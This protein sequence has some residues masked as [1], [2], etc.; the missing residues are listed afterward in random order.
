MDWTLLAPEVNLAACGYGRIDAEVAATRKAV[1]KTPLMTGAI[2][3]P[4]RMSERRY[5]DECS[6]ARLLRRACDANGGILIYHYP[7]LDGRSFEAIAAISRLIADHEPFFVHSET[8]KDFVNV[9][10]F[11]TEDVAVLT[12]GRQQYLLM[13]LNQSQT[14]RSFSLNLPQYKNLRNAVNGEVLQWPV[15]GRIA[16]GGFRAFLLE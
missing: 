8:V 10:G 1:G 6:Q 4:Y 7:S 15:Q 5:P 13:L 3:Y 11:P 9:P 16:P 12:D 2:V 14:A